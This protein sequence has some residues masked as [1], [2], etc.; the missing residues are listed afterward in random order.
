M[1]AFFVT[2]N[3]KLEYRA[4]VLFFL[5]LSRGTFG[6]RVDGCFFFYLTIGIYLT[7]KD[8][9]KTESNE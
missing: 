9:M 8:K 7:M 4:F 1:F 6:G 2:T 3:F 5:F